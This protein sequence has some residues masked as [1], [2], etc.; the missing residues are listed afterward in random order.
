MAWKA[1]CSL[2]QMSKVSHW[3]KPPFL[4]QQFNFGKNVPLVNFIFSNSISQKIFNFDL[5]TK[6][7]YRIM[8]QN[9]IFC[10]FNFWAKSRLLAR[11]FNF[12]TLLNVFQFWCKNSNMSQS[13]V[14]S[15]LNFWTKIRL[16][17]ECGLSKCQK[18]WIT[19]K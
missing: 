18:S 17:E 6:K 7:N 16:L 11:K 19:K 14:L 5:M 4:L 3:S 2:E 12:L 1:K 9:L 15:K 10:K 8:V 13:K